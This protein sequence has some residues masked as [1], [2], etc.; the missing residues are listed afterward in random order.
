M[1]CSTHIST[2]LGAQGAE[3]EK[4]CNGVTAKSFFFQKHELTVMKLSQD[5]FFFVIQNLSKMY[6]VSFPCGLLHDI[7]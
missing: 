6:P 1:I 3:T 5:S 2:L 7:G 4:T